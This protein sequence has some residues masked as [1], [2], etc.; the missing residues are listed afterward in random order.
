MKKWNVNV[1]GKLNFDRNIVLFAETEE[2]A[3]DAAEAVIKDVMKPNDELDISEV[4]AD[5]FKE[6]DGSA[7]YEIG[8]FIKGGE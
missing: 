5:E 8:Y 1:R 6:D 3:A 4:Y 7:K 2:Q